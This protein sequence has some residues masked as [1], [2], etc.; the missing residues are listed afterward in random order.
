[1]EKRK[2]TID[3]ISYIIYKIFKQDEEKNNIPQEINDSILNLK[4]MKLKKILI[5]IEIYPTLIEHFIE[6]LKMK[7]EMA[8]ITPGEAVG[9]LC[10]QSIGEK[11]TQMTL[12]TF[13]AAGMTIQ[14]V[15]TGVPRFLELLNASKDPKISSTCCHLSDE[16]NE[17]NL[18]KEL[19]ELHL[20]DFYVNFKICT[21]KPENEQP[22]WYKYYHSFYNE[23]KKKYTN[24]YKKNVYYISYTM[25]YEKLYKY[26]IYL[27]EIVEKLY[28]EYD[29]SV[30]VWESKISF[31]PIIG[32]T[33]YLYDFDNVK[34]LSLLSPKEWKLDDDFIGAYELNSDRKW[35]KK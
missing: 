26:N 28:N 22:Y 6:K 27:H 35:I 9:I 8:K 3:E 30:M 23:Y 11:Q 31:E 33:Y 34:T 15:V 7:Y 16:Y 20:N 18:S 25:N 29:T 24:I 32:K 19:L 12:N 14:T 4:K 21:K 17:K 5:K 13:H 1:M 10:A 2:L